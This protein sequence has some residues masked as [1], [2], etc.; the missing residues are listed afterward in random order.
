MAR[1]VRQDD[2]ALVRGVLNGAPEDRQKFDSRV[3]PIVGKCLSSALA[4]TH[5]EAH[6]EDLRQ[7]FGLFLLEGKGRV[8][9]TYR[10]EAA[11][12]TWIYAVAARFFRREVVRLSAASDKRR[13]LDAVA[14][15]PDREAPSPEDRSV[16]KQQ[17]EALRRVVAELDPSDRLMLS[18]TY[19]D[20]APSRVVAQAMGLSATGVRMRKKR[21]L[22]RLAQQLEGLW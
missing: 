1:K 6:R 22:E 14:D 9:Q 5:L 15:A 4:G 3:A 11:L 7:S 20:D 8:L 21:L 18:L 19:V 17:V 2:L 10:G 12:T 13:P 16:R